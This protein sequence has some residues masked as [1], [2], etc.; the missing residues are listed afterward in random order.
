MSKKD[1]LNEQLVKIIQSYYEAP[2]PDS[3][4][5][6]EMVEEIKSTIV[7]ALDVWGE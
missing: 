6:L 3:E 2:Y 5:V 1:Q 4:D 7:E